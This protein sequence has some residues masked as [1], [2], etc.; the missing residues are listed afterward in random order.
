MHK[1]KACV[2]GCIDFRFR[3]AT[4]NFLKSQ[5]WAD[6]YDLISVAGSSRDFIIPMKPE[7]AEYAWLQL[8]LSI[9]L[10]EPDL[11]VFM[12]HQDCGGY[13]QDGTIPGGLELEDDR[14]KHTEM[15]EQLKEKLLEKYP[16]LLFRFFHINFDGGVKELLVE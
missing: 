11:I 8:E 13:A 4:D 16:K 9:K 15:L 10:H 7:H 3:G 2:I 12:D 14:L 5:P 1:A 6:S